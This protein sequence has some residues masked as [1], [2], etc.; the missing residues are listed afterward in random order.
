MACATCH[1]APPFG[2]SYLPPSLKACRRTALAVAISLG[3]AGAAQAQSAEGTL[4]GSAAAGATVSIVNL[5]TGLQRQAKAEAGGNFVFSKLPPGRYRVT[6]GSVTREVEV[7]LGSGTQVK[8]TVQEM[9]RIEIS[10]RATRTSIDVTSVESNTV[11][12]AEQLRALPVARNIDAVALLAPGVVKGD[13]DLGD[14][15]GLPSFAGASVA[16]NGY[17]INGFDVTNIRN[18]LSYAN[19]PFEAIAQQQIKTGGYGAEYGRSLGG[20]I[21]LLTKQGTNEWKA[22][23]AVYWEPQSLRSKGRKVANNETDLDSAFPN[24]PPYTHYY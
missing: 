1:A 4:F 5:D 9:E 19:L 16:E 13:A 20:V 10:G 15:G 12:T 22:G 11:F 6:S 14:R 24:L 18:F 3:F 17:Y 23:G 7:A 21:S 8:L 2:K